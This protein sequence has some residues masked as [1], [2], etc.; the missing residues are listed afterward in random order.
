MPAVVQVSRHRP[1]YGSTIIDRLIYGPFPSEHAAKAWADELA[2]REPGALTHVMRL[3]DPN[4]DNA[5]AP[6]MF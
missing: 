5:A 2:A 6:P 4:A 1:G 3:T